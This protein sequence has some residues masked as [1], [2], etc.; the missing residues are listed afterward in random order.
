MVFTDVFCPRVDALQIY[1]EETKT[2]L[3]WQCTSNR[4]RFLDMYLRVSVWELIHRLRC[5]FID[6]ASQ[7]FVGLDGSDRLLTLANS[8]LRLMNFAHRI[9][10]STGTH[11]ELESKF[12]TCLVLRSIWWVV[13]EVCCQRFRVRIG[14]AIQM[15]FKGQALWLRQLWLS[16]Y[17]KWLEDNPP[18]ARG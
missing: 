1:G 13:Y 16:S 3:C 14:E 5:D 2:S 11:L 10:R 8:S 4:R 18:L 15:R 6:E 12:R 9:G 17:Q 7:L